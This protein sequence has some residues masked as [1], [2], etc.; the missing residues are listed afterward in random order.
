MKQLTLL[1][2][3]VFLFTACGE[4]PSRLKDKCTGVLND[5]AM[6]QYYELSYLDGLRENINSCNGD[7]DCLQSNY[8]LLLDKL[9]TAEAEIAL[10]ESQKL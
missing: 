3:L 2:T 4:S 6:S 10:E 5:P 9:A 1:S 8:E 7:T